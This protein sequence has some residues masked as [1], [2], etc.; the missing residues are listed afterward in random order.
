[1][2]L[3]LEPEESHVMTLLPLSRMIERTKI[4]QSDSD[5]ALFNALMYT[6]EMAI[7]L[8][9]AGMVAAVQDDG[10]R[11]RDRLVRR[12]LRADGIGIWAD[13][14]DEV[15][16][17]PSARYLDA[18]A[19][20]TQ[21]QLTQNCGADTWQY[22]AGSLMRTCLLK[23]RPEG[24]SMGARLQCRS[25]FRDFVQIRNATRG[26]GAA[27]P[28]KLEE[29]C[30]DLQ[31]S[32]SVFSANFDLFKLP[33][34]FIHRNMSGKYRVTLWGGTGEYLESLKKMTSISLSDGVYLQL[35]ELVLVELV[36]STADAQD[37]WIA[38]GAFT[39]HDHEYISYITDD[40]IKRKSEKYLIPLELLPP[41]ETQGIGDLDT[42]GNCFTNIPSLARGYVTR[43]DLEEALEAQLMLTDSHPIVSLTGRGGIGKTST[44]LKVIHSMTHK[45]VLPYG[46]IIWFSSRDIDLTID[47]PK[48]VQAQSVTLE[49]FAQE[50][51]RLVAPANRGERGFRPLDYF[52]EQIHSSAIGPT[53][54]IFD[55]FE[56]TSNSAE[57]FRWIDNLVRAPNKVL[58]TSRERNFT[59]DF[60]VPVG[61]MSDGE[62]RT[63]IK[64]TAEQLGIASALTENYVQELI[65]ESN[66][67]PYIIRLLLGEASKTNKFGNIERIVAGLDEALVA[68]FERSFNSLS[69]AA[70]RIFLTVSNW[71]SSVPAL[72][73]E[74]VLIR[75]EVDERVNVPEAIE[76]LV[77][78]SFV[79]EISSD[80]GDEF[81]IDVPLAA[82]LF[83]LKKLE[84]SEL[85][86]SIEVDTEL[87]QL[88]GAV[89][90][91]N[92]IPSLERRIRR[93]FNIVADIVA[94]DIKQLDRHLPILEFVSI[95]Y[96]YGWI[97]L[98]NLMSESF[99]EQ[100][101][102]DMDKYLLRYVETPDE[103][104]Y[105]A[106]RA[107]LRIADLKLQSNDHSGELYALAQICRQPKEPLNGISNA[108][109]RINGVL[110]RMGEQ[111]VRL[112][113]EEKQFLVADVVSAFEKH[114]DDLD[115]TD[116]SRL[117]WLYL[118]IDQID[119]AIDI[120]RRGLDLNP[121]N[122]YCQRFLNRQNK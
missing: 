122:D 106:A 89:Q 36:A 65:R 8:A 43:A 85:R 44:A 13:V 9:V 5:L 20:D 82:R 113:R 50:Y 6:G 37:V 17:G 19:Q 105:P 70:K 119:S 121:D 18:G 88:F 64:S 54:F 117:A 112:R 59:G 21:K 7:K 80:V 42:L 27:S 56:T 57:I 91:E 10:E 55:N 51:T 15:L 78:T 58:I 24:E 73:L 16:I 72:G 93:L 103:K 75:P 81:E 102:S 86:A 83:G 118:H 77:R 25:W 94:G 76:E 104:Q 95:R 48:T 108:A 66:G 28:A 29:I 92:G 100:A 23:F 2:D 11:H 30:S 62:C 68:L 22:H 33:W 38:N 40:R 87:L 35:Q 99:E 110:R 34:A 96:P 53:L 46:L 63:L 26:H 90:A 31:D 45:E 61:G 116:C 84:A 41:S 114:L 111:T 12:L 67:H 98:A 3:V 101:N 107:W 115:A 14:L 32:I 109:N 79:E 52:A 39:D 60:A 71:R 120:A 49:D 97:L 69:P 74:A 1:M 4:E 47:G